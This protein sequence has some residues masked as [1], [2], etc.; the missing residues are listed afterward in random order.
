MNT[1]KMVAAEM[2]PTISSSH[3]GTRD[4]VH[5]RIFLLLKERRKKA[6]QDV[7]HVIINI[8]PA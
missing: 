2:C 3:F 7:Y 4:L 8:F 6:A 1:F 5:M